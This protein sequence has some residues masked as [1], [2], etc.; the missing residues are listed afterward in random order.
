MSDEQHQKVIFGRSTEK[1]KTINFSKGYKSNQ[2]YQISN[3]GRVRN[4]QGKDVYRIKKPKLYQDQLIYR[5]NFPAS[6]NDGKNLCLHLLAKNLVASHFQKDYKKGKYVVWKD[7]NKLNNYVG[8]ILVLDPTPGRSHAAKGRFIKKIQIPVLPPKANKKAL[9]KSPHKVE[10]EYD[11]FKAIPNF[12][13][14]EINRYG[15]IRRRKPPFAGKILKQRIH[16]DKFYF[17][18][19][20]DDAKK[21]RTLY[22]HKAVA[23]TWNINVLPEKRKIVIHKDGDTLNNFSD[24]LEWVDHSEALKYQFAHN[25]RDNRK[26]WKTRKKRYG[27][28][29]IKKKVLEEEHS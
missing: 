8:N 29:G 12:T 5:F 11:Y 16:P 10:S 7:Y 13:A 27:K 3:Y 1:W 4:Y 2:V 26:S 22:T 21:R 17:L 19:L 20:K 9:N 24:N 6:E 15:I 14:Y 28:S 18:D 23:I 25:Q